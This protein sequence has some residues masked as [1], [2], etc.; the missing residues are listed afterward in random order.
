MGPGAP[1]GPVAPTRPAAPS[2]PRMPVAP[3]IRR[4]VTLWIITTR[5]NV[6]GDELPDSPVS[7]T[8]YFKVDINIKNNNNQYVN[9]NNTNYNNNNTYKKK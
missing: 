8:M 9:T 3:A 5:A 7:M 6:T 4:T 2:R 1:R